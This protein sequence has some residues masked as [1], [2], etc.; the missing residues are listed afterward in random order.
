[1][2]KGHSISV[3]SFQIST[4]NLR[5]NIQVRTVLNM[6]A[7]VIHDERYSVYGDQASDL[8]AVERWSKQFREGRAELEEESRSGRTINEMTPQ[9]IE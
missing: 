6:K 1:M 5:F 9:S 7:R 4:G 2:S 8:S 3:S